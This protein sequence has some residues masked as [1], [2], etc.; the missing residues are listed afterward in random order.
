[1]ED[2]ELLDSI[3]TYLRK[4]HPIFQTGVEKLLPL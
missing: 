3:Q 1:M 2:N 4:N